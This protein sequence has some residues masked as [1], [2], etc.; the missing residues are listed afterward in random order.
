MRDLLIVGLMALPLIKDKDNQGRWD[1][2]VESGPDAEV[3]GFFVNLGPTGARAVL[4]EKTFVVKYVFKDSPARERLRLG[5]V[6]T[7]AFGKP[8]AA[9]T[10]GGDVHGYE[11]PMNVNWFDHGTHVFFDGIPQVDDNLIC[12]FRSE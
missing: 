3:P 10:F 4:T 7:G 12:H 5:D 8:F 1:K 11:G 2:R 9:H 6:I